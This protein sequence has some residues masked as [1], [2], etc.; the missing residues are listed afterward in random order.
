MRLTRDESER[1][2]QE[3]LNAA[4]RLFRERGFDGVGV[5]DLM[6]AAGF[7][8]GGF[9]NHFASKDELEAEASG[10]AVAR[11]NSELAQSLGK[12]R[13]GWK[14]YVREYLSPGHRD[15][16]AHGC[17]M[18]ALAP[19]AARKG[20]ELQA[21]FAEAI[22]AFV[23]ILGGELA[24]KPKRGKRPS[25]KRERALQMLSEMIG[26]VVLSRAVAAADPKLSEEILTASRHKL[27]G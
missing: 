15:D 12:G 3:I 11:A 4:E 19:D 20:P 22:E 9:Y 23:G 5:A 18:A 27:G 13:G 10:A 2:R 17:T 24:R 26:A 7:T 16:A 6:K 8:H 1:N 14:R 21:R 25:A